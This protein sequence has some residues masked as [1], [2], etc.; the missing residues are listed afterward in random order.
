MKLKKYII[1]LFLLKTSFVVFGQRTETAINLTQ[2]KNRLILE[3]E[4]DILFTT[5]NYYTAGLAIS[6]T[7]I[8]IKK[9]PAQ[10]FLN[11]K[12]AGN[13]T[14][15]GFGIEHRM[16]TPFSIADPSVIENDRPYSAYVL[17]TNFAVLINVKKNV[18]LSNEIGVGIMGPAVKG[19]EVQT[20]V[21]KFIGSV[22]PVGWENQLGNTFLLDYQFRVEKGFF[23]NWISNHFVPFV[24]TRVG[25]LM[26]ELQIGLISKIGNKNSFLANTSPAIKKGFIWEWVFEANLKGVFYDA[27]LEGSLFNEDDAVVLDKQETISQQY[28]LRT[29]VNLYYKNLSFRYMVKYNSRNFTT[30]TIHRYASLNIGLA[31]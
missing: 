25:T 26:D 21:H 31:F 12:K 8:S 13:I 6:Y 27:T 20:F 1:A 4:N 19:K 17:A 16:F 15:N 11:S 2:E 10:L 24:A 9:T 23:K 5:D 30:A 3:G 28:Q 7:N 18:K 14:F 22:L 29:G